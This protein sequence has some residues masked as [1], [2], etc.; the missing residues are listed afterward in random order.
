MTTNS[1][2][3]NFKDEYKY[4][5]TDQFNQKAVYI[6]VCFLSQLISP[7]CFVWGVSGLDWKVIMVAES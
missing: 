4:K 1:A 2:G 3:L 6:S 5:L 7:I